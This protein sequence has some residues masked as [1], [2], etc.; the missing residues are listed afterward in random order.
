[1]S[2]QPFTADEFRSAAQAALEQAAAQ[3]AQL[4]AGMASRLRPFPAF[5]GTTSVQ[6]VE[7]VP[8][9]RPT[10]DHGCVVVTPDGAICRLDLKV[11]PGAGGLAEADQ[12]EEFQELALSA[13]EYILYAGV[14][15]GLLSEELRRR[16]G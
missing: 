3:L 16:G 2:N 8:A 6:A 9:W 13:E 7:L 14:A 11:I 4:L 15:L 1:M 5:L 10:A 12:V